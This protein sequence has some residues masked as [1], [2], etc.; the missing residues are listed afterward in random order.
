MCKL[1][2]AV[3]NY[4]NQDPRVEQRVAQRLG[5]RPETIATQV[6]PRDRHAMF[7][8]TLA[9][10][11]GSVENLATEIR[12]LARTEVREVQ[13]AF[14]RGQK[15]SS[16]MPH[17]KNPIL[18]ENLTGLARLVRSSVLPALE[19]ITLWHERDISHSSVERV[20]APD[21]TSLL[22]FA[23]V[24]LTGLMSGLVVYPERMKTNLESLGDLHESGRILLELVQS[25][26]NR[27]EAYAWVQKH[28]MHVWEHGGSLK[29][30]ISVKTMT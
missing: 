6:I 8:T 1:S 25:G 10:L 17:K 4:A 18:S 11:A 24:R 16:A 2:G 3:G 23:L 5:L 14:S 28:A 19:N 20:I 29:S 26:M 12:H 15:G 13:E 7:F 30:L 9:V 22:D 27:E 21:A